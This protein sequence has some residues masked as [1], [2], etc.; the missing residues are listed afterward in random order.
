LTIATIPALIASGSS[1]QATM[2]LQRRH[3]GFPRV[4]VENYATVV[5]A[6]GE[7]P[8]PGRLSRWERVCGNLVDMVATC[9]S[10]AND[11]I[12]ASEAI[13][14]GQH[15]TIAVDDPEQAHGEESSI[16]DPF[17]GLE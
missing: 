7:A 13:G 3:S 5:M 17:S 16:L 12:H 4:R 9:R 14:V 10:A 2:A 15:L 8:A 6:Y 11:L 1:G